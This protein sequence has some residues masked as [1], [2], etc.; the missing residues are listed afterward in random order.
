MQCGVSIL[1][2]SILAHCMSMLYIMIFHF[3]HTDALLYHTILYYKCQC[4]VYHV[5][6][7]RKVLH[8]NYPKLV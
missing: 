6:V 7:D 5:M 3:L 2:P 4:I 1:Y 8:F